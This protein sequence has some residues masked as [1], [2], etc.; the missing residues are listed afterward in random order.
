MEIKFISSIY[1]H[2]YHNQKPQKYPTVKLNYLIK[3]LWNESQLHKEKN[4]IS[5][6]FTSYGETI[7][8]TSITIPIMLLTKESL[9]TN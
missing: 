7:I 3:R 4:K 9:L 6:F 8:K 2:K 1:S 5:S